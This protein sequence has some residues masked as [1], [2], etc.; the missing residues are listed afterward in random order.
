MVLNQLTMPE[1]QQL[2]RKTNVASYTRDDVIA[3][4]S[5]IYLFKIIWGAWGW[6]MKQILEPISFQ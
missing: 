1:G 4:H 2:L 5:F 3:S 6:A